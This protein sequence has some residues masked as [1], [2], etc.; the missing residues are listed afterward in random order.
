MHE[1][2]ARYIHPHKPVSHVWRTTAKVPVCRVVIDEWENVELEEHIGTIGHLAR[3]LAHQ[4]EQ[5]LRIDLPRRDIAGVG[6]H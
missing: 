1:C 6:G 4:V 2:L 5:A 3:E